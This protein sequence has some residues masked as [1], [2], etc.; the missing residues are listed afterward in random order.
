MIPGDAMQLQQA[1]LLE[2]HGAALGGYFSYQKMSI[3]VKKRFYWFSI[4]KDIRQ[5]YTECDVY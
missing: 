5:F 3:F 4:S 2:F 1:I